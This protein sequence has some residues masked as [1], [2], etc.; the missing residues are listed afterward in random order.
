MMANS[1]ITQ[2]M[3]DKID[4]MSGSDADERMG[5]ALAN[6]AIMQAQLLA[7][8]VDLHPSYTLAHKEEAL[9]TFVGELILEYAKSINPDNKKT[10]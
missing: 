1:H 7:P 9:L 4:A 10:R 6:I 3:I 5:V 8:K 2:A